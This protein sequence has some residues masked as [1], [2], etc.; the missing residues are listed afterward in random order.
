MSISS[1]KTI[2]T[3]NAD[4]KDQRGG[5]PENMVDIESGLPTEE[6]EK[7]ADEILAEEVK[8]LPMKQLFPAFSAY[9]VTH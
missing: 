5:D 9:V 8:T 7:T 1:S 4:N 2:P 6:E 3:S